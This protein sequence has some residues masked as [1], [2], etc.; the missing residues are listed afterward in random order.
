MSKRRL[1]WVAIM[2]LATA[3]I[4]TG[5]VLSQTDGEVTFGNAAMVGLIAAVLMGIA[6]ATVRRK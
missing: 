2:S 3:S 5:W 6:V 4:V 1:T